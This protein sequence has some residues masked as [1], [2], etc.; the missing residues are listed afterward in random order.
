MEYYATINK[1]SFI[2]R[3]SREDSHI[4]SEKKKSY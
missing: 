4:I 2:S 1:S 3:M